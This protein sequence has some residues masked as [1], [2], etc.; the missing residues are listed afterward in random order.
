M[1]KNKP[2]YSIFLCWLAFFGLVVFCC[3]LLFLYDIFFLI[4]KQDSTRISSFILITFLLTTL[5]NGYCC[6]KLDI[7]RFAIA[8]LNKYPLHLISNLPRSITSF[9]LEE[10]LIQRDPSSKLNASVIQ[11]QL[12][13]RLR[14]RH[15]SGWFI[16]D[17]LI[18]LGLLG[19]VIGFIIMLNA[20]SQMETTDINTA[21][22]M[23]SNMSDGMR[24]ALITTLTGLSTGLLLG[25][26]YQFLDH[27]SDRLC[28]LITSESSKYFARSN[29]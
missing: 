22:L 6:Y 4:I 25:I 7:E 9:Y 29:E 12:E 16:A 2:A 21:K 23:L 11:I 1:P 28:T 19:T 18:K 13:Q 10:L 24:I 27:V 15:S 8:N 5:Y 26:Q 14:S 17:V 3:T 20:V